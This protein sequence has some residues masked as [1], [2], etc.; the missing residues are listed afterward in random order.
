[1]CCVYTSF[2]VLSSLK[3]NE[4]YNPWWTWVR[5]RTCHSDTPYCLCFS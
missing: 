4:W 2:P 5:E 3:W 1:M